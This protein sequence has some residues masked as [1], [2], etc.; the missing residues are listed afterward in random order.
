MQKVL[1]LFIAVYI[2]ALPHTLYGK[3]MTGCSDTTAICIQ[4]ANQR[5]DE[6]L[7]L[8]QKHYYKKNAVNWDSL[9]TAAR[10]RLAA[11]TDC[12]NAWETVNWCFRQMNESHSF[13]MPAASAALYNNDTAYLKRKPRITQ[14][15]GEIKAE[16]MND[17]GIA[18]LSVPWIGT[19]DS[20]ICSLLAD[21]LQQTIATLD[22][23]GVSKWII[24]LRKNTGG[25][26]WPMLAGI[27]PLLGDG[28]CGYFVSYTEKVPISYRNGAAMQGNNIRC[29]VT[30]AGYKTKKDKKWIIVLTGPQTSS[31]G[32]ILAL[33][34]KGKEQALLY[35]QPTAG[36]TTANTTYQLSD[37]SMLILTI[38]QEADRTGKVHEGKIYPDQIINTA[39]D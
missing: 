39:S 18:Y 12:F 33:A 32:E 2:I 22:Q 27:G 15:V 21:S 25:N 14:L 16:H 3:S 19:S 31:S 34:F 24:D 35:G 23:T 13:I 20:A 5:L 11:S 37:N 38:C 9:I 4:Q 7:T 36:L 6:V 28:I 30:K 10:S 26:C 8:M 29:K 1:I 17:K